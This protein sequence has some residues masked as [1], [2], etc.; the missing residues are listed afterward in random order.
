MKER[1]GWRQAGQQVKKGE[2]Q[3]GWD[4]SVR[5]GSILAIAHA[6][7]QT[8]NE[9]GTRL[10]RE[11]GGRKGS[12]TASGMK[13]QLLG[14]ALTRQLIAPPICPCPACA[15]LVSRRAHCQQAS[16]PNRHQPTY[17]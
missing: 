6:R 4:A 17:S 7:A 12:R 3:L 1:D 9:S 15:P 10:G 13:A 8:E 16:P 11:E 5:V 2:V 14:R